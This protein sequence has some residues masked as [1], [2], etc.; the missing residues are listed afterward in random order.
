MARDIEADVKIND[1]T[2]AGL[3]SAA[4]RVKATG[5]RINREGE[6]INKQYGS[7]LLNVVNDFSPK[8]AE[9]MAKSFRAAAPAIV[10][11]VAAVLPALAGIIGSSVAVAGVGAGIV[12]GVVLAARDARVQSAG[13]TLSE[14]LMTS[15]NKSAGVFVQ[16]LL[17]S[18]KIVESKFRESGKTIESIFRGSARFVEPLADAL[19]DVGQRLLEGIDSSIQN[20]GPVIESLTNGLRGTGEA[21]KS[22][23][24]DVTANAEGNAAVLDATFAALNGTIK[25][26]GPTIAF[27]VGTLEK[28][29]KIGAL[30]LFSN[31]DKVFGDTEKSAQGVASQTQATAGGIQ[32]AAN[33]AKAAAADTRLYEQALK[34]NAAA[35]RNAINAQVGLFS[36]TTSVGQAYADAKAA[37]AGGKRGLDENTK[38]GRT[39][40]QALSNLAGAINTYKTDL[41]GAGASVT[42]VNAKMSTQRQRFIAVAT[43][44]TGSASKART[45]A[46]QLLG[47]QDRNTKVTVNAAGAAQTAKEVRGLVNSIPNSVNIDVNVQFNEGRLA[48]VERRLARI[49]GAR[50]FAGAD[51]FGLTDGGQLARVGGPIEVAN[52][53]TIN[54]DGRPFREF[55]A[56]SVREESKRTAFRNKVGRRES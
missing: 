9:G 27:L 37:V 21:I 36:S 38:A 8:L 52:S 20:A 13:R 31:L 50:G 4:R 40:R 46:N 1:K 54:L 44:M 19:G 22:F 34:D 5:E 48:N 42:T 28:L 23:M 10:P 41:E 56:R 2:S 35:E 32:V 18:M 3:E 30:S 14:N 53:T 55:T 24:E 15:L 45:L 29:D 17:N 26:L 6:N 7:R 43:A 25:V 33:A 39:N 12:A 49:K 51:S 16:P 47:I 11:A